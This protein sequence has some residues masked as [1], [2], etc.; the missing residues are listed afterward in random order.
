MAGLILPSRLT[1]QPQYP[2]EL[3]RSH[4]L[5]RGLSCFYVLNQLQWATDLVTGKKGG[6]GSPIF[7]GGLLK[8]TGDNSANNARLPH[9]LA[10]VSGPLTF[11]VGF[12]RLSGTV[13]W[14]L[15]DTTGT[16]WT[17]YYGQS[18]DIQ[19]TTANDF[20]GAL[21]FSNAPLLGRTRNTIG[22]LAG[23]NN[24]YGAPQAGSL[25][26]DSTTSSPTVSN[27]LIYLGY[28]A[29][30]GI[31]DNP[32]VALFSHFGVFKGALSQA[33]AVALVSN[34]WQIVKAQ[35]R[36]LFAFASAAAFAIQDATHGHAADNLVLTQVHNLAM[37]DATHAQA[38]DVVTL[39]SPS[40]VQNVSAQSLTPAVAPA[41]ASAPK[42][43]N[44]IAVAITGT[45][46]PTTYTVS[47]NSSNTWTSQGT[48]QGSGIS[49]KVFTTV[50]SAT[51]S[52]FIITA[53]T[54]SAG[55]TPALM[56]AQEVAGVD[57]AILDGSVVTNTATAS[58]ITLGVTSS[59][60]KS[61]ILEFASLKSSS[62]TTGYATAADTMVQGPKVLYST[63]IA[64]TLHS[65]LLISAGTITGTFSDA[66]SVSQAQVAIGFA[67]KA[68]GAVS[69]LTV[70][71]GTHAQSSDNLALTQNQFL[72]L[73]DALHGHLAS[74][75]A[76]TQQQYLA[77]NDALHGHSADNVA[78]I[79]QQFLALADAT[80]G[81][82]AGTLGLTQQ[83]ILALSD[84][85]HG[86]AAD[87]VALTQQQFLTM[88]DAVHGHLADAL[89][90]SVATNIVLNDIVHGHLGDNLTLTQ[91]QF[92]ILSDALHGHVADN[93]ALTQANNLALS[94][95]LHGQIVDALALTQVHSITVGDATHGQVA[96]NVTLTQA[97]FLVLS[98]I[99]HAHLA[100]SI[101]LT[102]GGILTIADAFHGHLAD[103]VVLTSDQFLT[104]SDALHGQ[105]AD[106]LTLTQA[107]SLALAD[108]VHGQL[109][110]QL[111]L[112]QQQY[113][114]TADATHG[115][116]ADTITLGAAGTLVI[117]DMIHGH[118]ADNVALTQVHAILVQDAT[119]GQSAD[120]VSLSQAHNLTMADAVHGMAS[121]SIALSS[122][123]TLVLS[124]V[125]HAHSA[126]A[127]TLSVGYLLAIQDAVHATLADSVILS[128]VHQLIVSDALHG[129]LSNNIAFAVIP[130]PDS[131]VLIVQAE[132]R[133][134][135]VAREDRTLTVPGENRILYVH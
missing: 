15:L 50:I 89:T 41:F 93:L 34:P 70:N 9:N 75:I 36:R 134:L 40:L 26:A 2:V 83:Q 33:E 11:L 92:L 114:S 61:L 67:L 123:A 18:D 126:D 78:L 52:N 32:A 51:S 127:V 19:V 80:H 60:A 128:Q 86:H 71:D 7:D 132:G 56:I 74:G 97:Q 59:F 65:K 10:S 115:H 108:A 48:A 77:L 112:I 79:Q 135:I 113:L 133:I 121:D 118:A 4:P 25:V 102:G 54:G 3:D 6:A 38:A 103:N 81:Q 69:V 105:V 124:D 116:S 125:T 58:S 45:G 76:L 120:N 5:T 35:R 16:N 1:Q 88:A 29:R 12:S 46:D 47:D 90:L 95:M 30:G 64:S 119:H 66:G 62:S 101:T 82:L 91:A 130:T 96:D 55:A 63:T 68:S 21:S 20:A 104:L 14:S 111:T 31:S 49:K 17:G 13:S 129:L 57:A 131:R 94:D 27:S 100:D 42:I 84:A 117:P 87:G 106:N 109:A 99:L 37:Q 122:S 98:D 23:V 39:N 8:T 53:V 43:G 24:L 85:I 44:L 22:V 28:S 110:D 73:Q 72:A 107:H